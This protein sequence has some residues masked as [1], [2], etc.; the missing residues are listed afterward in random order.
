VI[1]LP[2]VLFTILLFVCA[3][4]SP[5]R[6]QHEA[7]PSDEAAPARDG[8]GAEAAPDAD[9]APPPERRMAVT[10]DDLPVAFFDSHRNAAHRL[11]VV[12][13]W[14]DLVR[15][16]SLPVT[17]FLV[18]ENHPRQPELMRIWLE[19]GI[20]VGNHTWS[21]PR[22]RKVG[23]RSYLADLDRGHATVAGLIPEGTKIPFRYPY[24][25][26]GFD[27]SHRDAVRAHL[28]ELG[29]PAAPVTVDSNDWLYARHYGDALRERDDAAAERAR[30]AWRWDLEEA[31]ERAEWRSRQLFDREPPQILLVHANELTGRH[32]GEYLDWLEGRGYRFISL[33]DAL[34]DP[35]Y[36]ETDASLVPTGDS[37]WL[38]LRR[39]RQL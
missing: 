11:E 39:S 37:F 8:G 3:P 26:Q 20:G 27:P 36:A 32:L 4:S 31:T 34:A 35:A 9:P 24:L 2:F 7:V 12:Q 14:R 1:R 10:V 18:G 13:T 6:P 5:E 17:G 29:S 19:A 15:S 23:L 38:R 21:H 25:Y 30:Q 16:R 33:A 22:L 28:A